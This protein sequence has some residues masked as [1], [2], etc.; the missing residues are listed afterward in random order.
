[1]KNLFLKKESQG[2]REDELVKSLFVRRMTPGVRKNLWINT[3][4]KLVSEDVL[5]KVLQGT[6][7][8]AMNV[9][10]ANKDWYEGCQVIS[11]KTK[12]RIFNSSEHFESFALGAKWD[13]NKGS[14][15]N[16]FISRSVAINEDCR[17]QLVDSISTLE[18]AMVVAHGVE[19]RHITVD[20][21]TRFNSSRLGLQ[22]PPQTRS[23]LEAALALFR[24]TMT[25]EAGTA[26]FPDKLCPNQVHTFNLNSFASVQD[27]FKWCLTSV[28]DLNYEDGL[29]YAEDARNKRKASQT[30]QIGGG[31]TLK[32]PRTNPA[33]P[34][35]TGS[36]VTQPTRSSKGL[37]LFDLK[38]AWGCPGAKVCTQ[39]AKCSFIHWKKRVQSDWPKAK[40]ISAI[41]DFASVT[42][43]DKAWLLANV[44]KHV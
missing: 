19:W 22:S 16:Q 1:M 12:I 25:Q 7:R 13:S 4:G 17:E 40:V 28:K 23:T 10:V 37:C 3:D 42:V 6:Q 41:N 20:L 15:M 14:I 30:A 26:I 36:K 21:I 31:P 2:R 32:I 5:D 18:A 9:H 8:I 27:F 24:D 33:Q 35:N 11:L 39:H 44:S 38:T 29:V 43:A 34:N